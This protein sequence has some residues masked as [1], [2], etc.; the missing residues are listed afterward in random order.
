[1]QTIP[2]YRY[3]RPDGGVTVSPV[4]PDAEYAEMFRLVADEGHVLTN[5][6][7]TTTCVDTDKPSLWSEVQATDTINEEE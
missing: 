2:L 6:E 5:G 7:D 3:I 4:K 1:M